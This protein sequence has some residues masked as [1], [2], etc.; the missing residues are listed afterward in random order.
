MTFP[1]WEYSCLRQQQL[2]GQI[3]HMLQDGSGLNCFLPGGEYLFHVNTAAG[4]RRTWL[5]K[6]IFT[7]RI[8]P[9]PTRITCDT[10]T[11]E[12]RV[13]CIVFIITWVHF[14]VFNQQLMTRFYPANLVR[15]VC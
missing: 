12:C 2:L 9:H 7:L 11:A 8:H 3:T 4:E 13:S 1:E 14:I 10:Y 6:L 15:I 5:K